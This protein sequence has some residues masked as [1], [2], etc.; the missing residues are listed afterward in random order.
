MGCFLF[1]FYKWVPFPSFLHMILPINQV[2]TSAWICSKEQSEG[3]LVPLTYLCAKIILFWWSFIIILTSGKANPIFCFSFLFC[4]S[5]S[6]FPFLLSLSSS[7]YPFF[8]LTG[9]F[10]PLASPK[11]PEITYWATCL[12]HS[13]A[14]RH[15][16]S[17]WPSMGPC[18]AW[19][20]GGQQWGW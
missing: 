2:H 12:Q 3:Y 16:G 11:R 9:N 13:P 8:R 7:S 20:P 5:F 19:S 18:K 17:V 4:S 15:F 14:G 1:F 6:C 10:L